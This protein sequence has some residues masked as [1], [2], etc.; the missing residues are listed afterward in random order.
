MEQ[1]EFITIITK[2]G[3]LTHNY[4]SLREHLLNIVV[5]CADT[6]VTLEVLKAVVQTS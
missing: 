1:A 2:D 5:V 3:F 6:D 4:A